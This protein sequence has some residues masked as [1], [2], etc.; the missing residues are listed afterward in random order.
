VFPTLGA[1]APPAQRNVARSEFG[2]THA[3]VHPASTLLSPASVA[4]ISTPPPPHVIGHWQVHVEGHSK[5]TVHDDGVC[6]ATH[7][8][9][10]MER[11]VL[12]GWQMGGMA[13]KPESAWGSNG[14]VGT[15]L[16]G[17][18]MLVS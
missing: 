18:V 17:M 16:Q 15:A 13:G 3:F 2:G 5:A 12:P 7:V 14:G 8:F 6:C 4:G 11:Q 1:S 9:E 10:V